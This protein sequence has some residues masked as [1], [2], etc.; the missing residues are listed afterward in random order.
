[1]QRKDDSWEGFLSRNQFGVQITH[2]RVIPR[3]VSPHQEDVGNGLS[4][5]DDLPLREVIA[6]RQKRREQQEK[7]ANASVRMEVEKSKDEGSSKP[8]Q[9]KKVIKRVKKVI[10]KRK[11]K[12][13]NPPTKTTEIGTPTVLPSFVETISYDVE[14]VI[15]NRGVL[16]SKGLP[17]HSGTKRK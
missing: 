12:A 13:T 5:K 14:I 16:A 3:P 4:D 10:K 1:M 2:T 11:K 17:A 6:L 15:K 9:G 8:K 7:E